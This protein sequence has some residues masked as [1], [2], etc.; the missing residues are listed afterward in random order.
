LRRAWA[1]LALLG[2]GCVMNLRPNDAEL[3]TGMSQAEMD[4]A[5]GHHE[6]RA[7]IINDVRK[8]R[9]L[10]HRLEE[11]R[12]GCAA[13]TW[14][15]KTPVCAKCMEDMEAYTVREDQP[16][17][18]YRVDETVFYCRKESQYYYHYVGGKKRLDVWLG[19]YALERKRVKPEE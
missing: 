8:W 1:A 10:S 18:S 14:R 6:T 4:A 12:A 3:R 9:M 16:E 7:A 13:I 19:P 11:G 17:T 2:S 5:P 15:E